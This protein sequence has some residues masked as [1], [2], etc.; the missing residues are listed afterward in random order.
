MCDTILRVYGCIGTYTLAKQVLEGCLVCKKTN[1]KALRHTPSVGRNPGLRPRQ[2]IQIDYT[3]M[4]KV[5]R[6]RYLLVILDHL[7]HWVEA[8][9]LL[10]ATANN[11][12]KALLEHII[13]RFGIV[14][15]IQ[16]MGVICP[17]VF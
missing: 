8:I 5:G 1:K 12:I 9:P 11:V 13:P 4:P 7:S 15:N 2:S 6:L 16:T 14:E 17:P 3:K 10:G